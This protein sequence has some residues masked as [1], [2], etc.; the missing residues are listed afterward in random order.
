MTKVMTKSSKVNGDHGLDGTAKDSTNVTLTKQAR[1]TDQSKLRD[2][3]C[4]IYDDILVVDNIHLAEEVAK[5][6]TTKY[7]HLIYAC[8]TEV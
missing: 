7:R 6:L 5:M 3:L 2:R 1:G 8:D 4:S